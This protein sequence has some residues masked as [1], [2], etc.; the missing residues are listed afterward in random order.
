MTS[1]DICRISTSMKNAWARGD[2]DTSIG[3]VL[4]PRIFNFTCVV[5]NKPFYRSSKK[6]IYNPIKTCSEQCYLKLL[7][8]N[9]RENPNCGGELGY[10]HYKYNGVT[11]DST[12]EVNLAKWMDDEKIKWDRSRHR[13]MF[14]W[15]D[16][17][18]NKRRYY[19]DFYL[20]EYNV[21]LDP[22]NKYKMENDR[23]KMGR[24]IKENRI[25][26]LWGLLDDVKKELDIIRDV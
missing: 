4:E 20:P 21:Y 2:F 7:S 6:I 11:M 24:V 25:T 14:W 18:G 22:K 12:W 17:D 3:R 15:T 26:L 19:P 16:D 1:E 23:I 8:K 13:H 9:S 10:K 5:C